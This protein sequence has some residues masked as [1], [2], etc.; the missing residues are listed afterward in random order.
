M[1]ARTPRLLLRPGWIE[2]APAL[3][4]AIADP[5]IIH[6]LA[7]APWPYGIE[8]AV[9]F[10]AGPQSPLL[11]ELLILR[12]T[13]GAPQVIGG[14]GLVQDEDGTVELGYWITRA[15]WGLGFA[16]EAG[17]AMLDIARHALGLEA[18]HAT[19]F[20]ANGASHH[21]LEKL[22]FKPVG[23]TLRHCASRDALVPATRFRRA[24]DDSSCCEMQNRLAA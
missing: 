5:A 19:A 10:L 17:Q 14:I 15:C 21:V 7:K 23:Q 2:D 4:R 9:H 16:T 13:M 6:N 18:I 22:G 1:F 12:R 24:L 20:T 11:P 3:T 8:E